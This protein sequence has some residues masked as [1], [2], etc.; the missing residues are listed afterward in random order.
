MSAQK[1]E[2]NKRVIL[3]IV[4][5][6]FAAILVEGL[7]L[8]AI[9][10]AKVRQAYIESFEEQLRACAIQ[11]YDEFN[12]EY[13]GDW[14]LSDEGRLLKGGED[15][16]EEY[17]SQLEALTAQTG[18]EYTL[19]YG[20][21]RYITSIK[22]E[23]GEYLIGTP[24]TD[25]VKATVLE[26]GEQYLA[27]NIIINGK[28]FYGYYVPMKNADG[29]V[30]GM[31]FTGKESEKIDAAVRSVMIFMIAI[32]AI[33]M[34][35]VSCIGFTVVRSTTPVMK[36]IVS[37]IGK[38][39]EGKLGFRFSDKVYE[40]DDE[41]GKIAEAT[42]E[43]RDR[44]AEVISTTL[45][46]SGQVEKSGSELSSS[47][48]LAS[49]ASG[50]V[51]DAVDEISKGAVSQAESV[52][53]SAGNTSEMGDNI[54]G[55]TFSVD[56]LSA[57][58][59]EMMQASNRTVEAL[60]KLMA[61]NQNVMSA[62]QEIDSQIRATNDAVKEIAD[63]SNVI[64]DISSQTNLLALNASIEA[65]RAGEAGRGFAVVATEI[66][67]LADQSGN[68]AVSINQIVNN[69]VTESQ[70][71]VETISN[72]NEGFAAQNEQLHATKNDMDGMVENVQNVGQS[73]R[74]IAEKV[75]LLNESRDRLNSIISDL[76]AI[77]EEN[78]A[79]TEETNASMQELNA[80]F[81]VINASAGDLMKLA[82][83]LN[84]EIRFF[85]LEDVDDADAVASQ[86]TAE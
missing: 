82:V 43:L 64:T 75:Q 28:K 51:T 30:V 85:T 24:C 39:S 36:E 69:L 13:D 6:A 2:K 5:I 4:M 60:E 42:A 21:T 48:D 58:A 86:V 23:K 10:L 22:D 76:S 78:A 68:A 16:Y 79:S 57:A 38:L 77:S 66:G 59:D 63:A 53:D 49:Q 33:I 46:L 9:G 81:E 47:A 12:Y 1:R 72:L 73:S 14:T 56:E 17:L 8:T 44:L 83:S 27:E 26:K 7:I 74:V 52:Q 20:D 41:F 25:V 54:D 50:Q 70:K 11:I 71:S 67:S 61:Q 62:M 65:A 80:T 35:I 15:I 18:V 32:A 45:D 37:N 3:K 84:E 34:L 55:I 29:S 31:A 19:F 40:R